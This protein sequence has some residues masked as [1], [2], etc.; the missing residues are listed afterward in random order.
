M[1]VDYMTEFRR[2]ADVLNSLF[3]PTPHMRQDRLFELVCTLVRAAG[4]QDAGWDARLESEAVLDDLQSLA[5]LDLPPDKFMSPERTRMRLWLLA[6][7]HLTEMDLPYSLLANLLHLRLGHK[8]QINPFADLARVVGKKTKRPKSMPASP[9]QKIVRIIQLSK[10]VSLTGVGDAM[11]EIHDGIIRNAVYHSDY[12]IYNGQVRLLKD[13]RLSARERCYTP[14]I[15]A[16]ELEELFCRTFA[17]Y[18]AFFSLYERSLKSFVDF[19]H[20]F[21][22]YDWHYKGLMDLVFDADDRLVGF[23]VYWP[24]GT[25][26]EYRRQQEGCIATNIEFN[27]D[28]SINFFV[29]LPASQPGPFSP[30]VE[31]DGMPKYPERPED[32]ISPYW[33]DDCK[34]YKIPP[35]ARSAG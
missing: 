12:V 22:P 13:S 11:H 1:N 18:G 25:L 8:Y 23:R 15:E 24:N 10:E 3:D 20:A 27:P 34:L 35:D 14:V 33:P 21:I 2:Y 4:M 19:R 28:Q 16:D 6:Y 30:L 31:R 26:S 9:N 7:C 32:A 5:N 17:F 29:G